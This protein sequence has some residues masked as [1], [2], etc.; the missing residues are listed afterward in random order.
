MAAMDSV[1]VEERVQVTAFVDDQAVIPEHVPGET[2][3]SDIGTLQ[4]TDSMRHSII[5]FLERPQLISCFSWKGMSND[6]HGQN[7]LAMQDPLD[8]SSIIMNPLVPS[9]VMTRMFVEK[10]QGF[11]AFRATA[12]FKLQ[13][14]SQSFQAGRLIFGAIPMPTLLGERADF[15]LK[16]P[17][18]ALSINHVQ[19]DINKQTE[20]ILRVPF[21]SPFNSYDLIN[22]QYDWARLFVMVYGPL[23]VV[24]D[25]N[26]L[27]CDLY[28]HFE[29]IEL[30][31]PTTAE[32][33]IT[34]AWAPTRVVYWGE[35]PKS[36]SGKIEDF[37][38][39]REALNKLAEKKKEKFLTRIRQ[40]QE[41]I[42]YNQVP[43][44]QSGKVVTK[45]LLIRAGWSEAE[46]GVI[47][48]DLKGNYWVDL[49]MT[50]DVKIKMTIQFT[51]DEIKGGLPGAENILLFSGPYNF[52]NKLD[53]NNNSSQ[54]VWQIF[55]IE[56][57][58]AHGPYCCSD[59]RCLPSTPLDISPLRGSPIEGTDIPDLRDLLNENFNNNLNNNDNNNNE[60]N[61]RR[62]NSIDIPAPIAPNLHLDLPIPDINMPFPNEPPTPHDD[63]H[64]MEL[65]RSQSGRGPNRTNFRRSSGFQANR[66]VK[67]PRAPPK[68]AAPQKVNEVREQESDGVFAKSVKRF[69]KQVGS[70]ATSIGDVVA[71]VGNW[72]GWSK[73][74][75]SHSGE[76]V[77]IRPAQ[78]FGNTNG[79]D[80]SHVLS[81]DLM[82]N[83]DEYPALAGSD[84]DELSFDFV[85][86]IPQFIGAFQ[87]NQ[88]NKITVSNTGVGDDYLWSCFVLPNYINPACFK[89]QYTGNFGDEE[90][91]ASNIISIQNPTSLGYACAPFA[92]WTGSLVYTFRFVKTNYNSGRVEI[93]FHP[94]FYSKNYGG[95]NIPAPDN[96]RFQYAYKVV[97]DLEQNSEVSLT[98][99][100]VSPQQWK[101]LSYYNQKW[102]VNPCKDTTDWSN[103]ELDEVARCS[104]GLLWVRALTSLHTQGAVAPTSILC[105]VECRAGDDFA[106]Q[107]PSTTRYIPL[108]TTPNSQSGKVYATS[109]TMDT[110]T[111]ALEGFQPPSITGNDKDMERDDT[112]LLCAGEIFHNFRQ[113]IKRNMFVRAIYQTHGN[114]AVALY[115]NEFI[116]P[117]R[118]SLDIYSYTSGQGESK[119]VSYFQIF[120]IPNWPSPLSYVS[121]MYCFYRGGVRFK[122]VS[123]S[124]TGSISEGLTS[125]RLE[126]A[127]YTG[128]PAEITPKTTEYNAIQTF[129][130]PVHYEQKEKNIG[131]F[132][133]P[134][135]SPTLQSVPWSI[136]GGYLYDNPLP[137]IKV[138]SSAVSGSG[139]RTY[140]NFHIATSASDDFDL[141]YFLGAPLCFRTSIWQKGGNYTSGK[142]YPYCSQMDQYDGIAN[143]DPC[144]NVSPFAN[145][146]VPTGEG[147]MVKVSTVSINL[148]LRNVIVTNPNLTVT[149]DVSKIFSIGC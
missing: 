105:L 8:P 93:S 71:S 45:G 32:C 144:F 104:T 92:Y 36:Q 83:V 82:N 131:E 69:A 23:N 13:I 129:S 99:P 77:V 101:A 11:T 79:I 130:S 41:A 112:Q 78:Y 46:E 67:Q 127:P 58:I 147:E 149:T 38:K 148:S 141:G 73:P 19:M 62:S 25:D 47:A 108:T 64:F 102:F 9:Q 110:R 72:L 76:T 136:R 70:V 133:V 81:L 122:I 103:L 106:V 114:S 18:S 88:K 86:R 124:Y 55:K 135:Y 128:V 97:V 6:F 90:A 5:S 15:I 121:G 33:T 113:Y 63:K 2:T 125:V 14:N 115:P 16:T 12:V 65:P 132:Q 40:Q 10:L 139:S 60:E 84:L 54:I 59:P 107:C 37:N 27:Q 57:M 43:Q 95:H 34:P 22:K 111:R 87:Y 30:G 3:L 134:Y 119:K 91:V 29:D 100:Y 126:V 142:S 123:T 80:H 117:P 31:C 50:A 20:V 42:K 143:A 118:V 21:I 17:C 75:L 1:G 74:Q 39:K 28:C 35:T 53:F 48:E 61:R 66:Q 51:C 145:G 96:Q 98:V 116:I 146:K 68:E 7:I 85:K 52:D 4:Y 49:W 89:V 44:S 140:A 24:G 137:Y 56:E 26:I 109:G 120:N 94:F 138:T